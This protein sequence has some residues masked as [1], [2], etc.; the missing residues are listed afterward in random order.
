MN[1]SSQPHKLEA[2]LAW[3]RQCENWFDAHANRLSIMVFAMSLM[4][5]LGTAWGTFLN[6]D[7]ALHYLIAN[8]ISWR[9]A[10]QA[11]LTTAHPPLLICLLYFWRK[12]GSAELTLRLP[13]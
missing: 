10:Y 11:S 3:S 4:V 13:S 6:P 8:Q 1:T 5:R 2:S 12:L 9:M 7:E